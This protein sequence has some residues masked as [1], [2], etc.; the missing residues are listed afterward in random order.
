[1]EVHNPYISDDDMEAEVKR[2]LQDT[3]VNNDVFKPIRI[4]FDTDALDLQANG[5]SNAQK[6]DFI[7]TEI[8]PRMG[9]FWSSALSVVPISGNLIIQRGELVDSQGAKGEMGDR[10]YCGHPELRKVP[11]SHFTTGIEDTDLILYVSGTPSSTFCDAYTLAVAVACNVDQFDRSIAGAINFCLEAIELN[12]DG[13]V[14]PSIIQDNVDVAIHEAAH[15][16]GM[17]SNALRFFRDPKTGERRT[18]RPFEE[19]TAVCIDGVERTVYLPDEN[20]LKFSTAANGQRYASVI[21]ETVVSVVRNQFDCQTLEGARLEN[22]PSNAGSCTGDHWDERQFY[23]ELLGAVT[24]PTTNYFSPLTLALLED[25]GWYRG[26]FTM[27]RTSPWGHGAGCDFVDKPCLINEGNEVTVPTYGEGYFCSSEEQRFGC[28]PSHYYKTGCTLFDH[29]ETIPEKFQYFPNFPTRGGMK[30]AD[31][32]PLYGAPYNGKDIHEHD[33]RD[34]NNGNYVGY[35]SEVYGESSMCFETDAGEGKCYEARCIMDEFVVK[36]NVGGEWYTCENDFQKIEAKV[37]NGILPITITCPR[38]TSICPDMFCPANCA[39]RGVCDYSVNVPGDVRPQCNCFNETDTSPGCTG[40]LQL[41]KP[42]I[43]LKPSS[44]PSASNQPSISMQPST[45]PSVTNRPS[46]STEPSVLPSL[47]PSTPLLS[48]SSSCLQETESIGLTPTLLEDWLLV[49]LNIDVANLDT[50]VPDFCTVTR[51]NERV[52]VA[53][54]FRRRGDVEV[55]FIENGIPEMVGIT[56]DCNILKMSGV[57]H[58]CL[59]KSCDPDEFYDSTFDEIAGFDNIADIL[60][61]NECTLS[62]EAVSDPSTF[63]LSGAHSS[64]SFTSSVL[65]TSFSFLFSFLL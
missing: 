2:S 41:M 17:N 16:L 38:L 18:L 25:S 15:I 53:C 19:K 46:K 33:C 35:H 63:L 22:R 28:S 44:S 48:P 1:L 13:T 52:S 62:A 51:G 49:F 34:P 30:Q 58:L 8:L 9:Q 3:I 29:S 64:W 7:K 4:K 55:C 39:G 57:A 45:S 5:I 6:V 40:G 59:G 60:G 42:S 11:S 26:N 65:L 21:T 50:S 14:H 54:D 10:Q 61:F 47:A 27:T 12:D 36:L 23:P 37:F 24:S 32:C 56:V 43:S 31:Y 20:T